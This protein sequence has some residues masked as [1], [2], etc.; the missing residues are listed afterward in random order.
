MSEQHPPTWGGQ[1]YPPI[2]YQPKPD[3]RPLYRK[4]WVWV[5]AAGLLLFGGCTAVMVAGVTS[6]DTATE[7]TNEYGI[8]RGAGSA[9]ASGDVR[10]GEIAAPDAIGVRYGVIHIT[11]HSDEASDYYIELRVLDANG[12]NIGMANATA[13]RVQPGAKAKAEFMVIEDEAARVE[14]TEVQRT[15]SL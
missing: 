7:T 11:N 3:P 4:V 8:S 15:A 6:I 9:D 2:Q 14:V 10:L 1:P 13:D 5:L 12:V